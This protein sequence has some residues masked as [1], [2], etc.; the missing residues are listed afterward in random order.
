MDYFLKKKKIGEMV[1]TRLSFKFTSS[2]ACSYCCMTCCYMTL[3]NIH[4]CYKI[5]NE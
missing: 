4:H 3:I 2:P 1:S 5:I